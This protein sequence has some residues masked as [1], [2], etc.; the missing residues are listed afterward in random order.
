MISK[1]WTIPKLKIYRGRGGGGG[2]GW[3]WDFSHDSFGDTKRFGAWAD[4]I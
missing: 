4:Y 3:L 2:G 1:Q